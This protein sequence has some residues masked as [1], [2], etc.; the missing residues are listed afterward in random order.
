VNGASMDGFTAATIANEGNVK[1]TSCSYD[2][3]K[4]KIELNDDVLHTYTYKVYTNGGNF[5]V[6]ADQDISTVMNND[7]VPTLPEEIK[8]PL[9]NMDQFKYY[10]AEADMGV[11]TKELKNIFGL[12]DDIVYVRY[13]DY[14]LKATEYK[15][16]NVRNATSETQVAKGEGSNDAALDI[17]GEL[18]YNIIWYDDNMM[19][20]VDT[21]VPADGA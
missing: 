18:I 10:G 8:S 12:Y 2:A 11:E 20:A 17:K 21:T 7:Y 19:K 1:S 9:L 16:P 3:T 13:A 14:D 5:A 6:S 4:A 15:V